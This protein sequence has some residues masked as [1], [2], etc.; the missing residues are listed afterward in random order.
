[1]DDSLRACARVRALALACCSKKKSRWTIAS[2]GGWERFG[3]ANF[4]LGIG[5]QRCD[6]AEAGEASPTD[7]TMPRA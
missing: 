7:L 1:M 2:D 3:G 6:V 5:S 4:T